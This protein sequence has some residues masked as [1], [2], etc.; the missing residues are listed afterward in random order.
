MAQDTTNYNGEPIVFRDDR[1]G[2]LSSKTPI[3]INRSPIE[4]KH[5]LGRQPMC[6]YLAYSDESV[7]MHTLD[8]NNESVIVDFTTD[9]FNAVV[10]FE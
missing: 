2:V 1:S 4:V 5:G 9:Q 6:V 8:K 3:H 7:R 10:R